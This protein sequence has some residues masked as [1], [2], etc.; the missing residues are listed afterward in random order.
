MKKKGFTLIELIVVIAII[1]VLAAILVPAMLGYVKKSKIT[2]A[3]TTAKSIYNAFNSSLTD[4]DSQDA[5]I[6]DITAKATS[7]STGGGGEAAASTD[8]GNWIKYDGTVDAD[9]K[10]NTAKWTGASSDSV[11]T[12]LRAKV[13]TYFS[14]VEKVK[15][16]SVKI[17]KGAC[18]AAVVMNGSYPGAY[19]KAMTVDIY[20]EGGDAA[21]DTSNEKLRGFA[22]SGVWSST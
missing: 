16:F 6:K 20:N 19:P 14:D 2:T 8:G 21:S 1:G 9:F 15:D 11:E 18:V 10:N 22:E 12:C 7:G 17:K 4:L 3:N 13:Y 5:P